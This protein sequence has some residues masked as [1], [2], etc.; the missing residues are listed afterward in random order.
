MVKPSF[1]MDH[2]IDSTKKTNLLALK[3]LL[4]GKKPFLCENPRLIINP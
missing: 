1:F 2:P 4:F 3:R